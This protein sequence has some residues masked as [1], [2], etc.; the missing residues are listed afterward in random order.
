[1]GLSISLLERL[2][3]TYKGKKSFESA[4]AVLLTNYRSHPGVLRLPSSLFYD[5]TLEVNVSYL[6]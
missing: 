3:E 2:M 6:T 5:N 1:M 4:K